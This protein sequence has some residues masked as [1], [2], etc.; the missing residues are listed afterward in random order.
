MNRP[1]HKSYFYRPPIMR[2]LRLPAKDGDWEL[3][4][5]YLP[6]VNA[7]QKSLLIVYICYL[8]TLPK[9]TSSKYLLLLVLGESG[10]GK[11]ALCNMLMDIIDPTSIGVQ[12]LPSDAKELGIIAK[13]VHLAVFD[14]ARENDITTKMSDVLCVVVYGGQLGFRKLYTD[15]SLHLVNVHFAPAITAI[16]NP[17][18][19]PDLASRCLTINLNS[20]KDEE[21][22]S[23]SVLMDQFHQDLP[24]IM[25]GIFNL[26]AELFKYLP[27]IAVEYPA[28][29]IDFSRYLAA[30][31]KVIGVPEGVYQQAYLFNLEEAQ[32]E[33][34]ADD[35]LLSTFVEYCER[36]RE[37]YEGTAKELLEDLSTLVDKSMR[38]SR[39]WPKNPSDLSKLIRKRRTILKANGIDVSF[40]PRGKRRLIIISTDKLNNSGK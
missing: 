19:E 5:K 16:E 6:N 26:I 11:T 20:L 2:G 8:L 18:L 9:Q 12:I 39:S 10:S 40:P 28:R 14:N 34:L 37:P 7:V 31:E 22:I 38:Y 35:L 17:V 3:L 29:M 21:R 13:N 23:D 33:T 1:N 27:D 36:L 24:V 30:F 25:A 15:D 4:F 32:T